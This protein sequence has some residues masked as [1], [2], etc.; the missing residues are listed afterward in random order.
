MMNAIQRRVLR[1]FVES[2]GDLTDAAQVDVLVRRVETMVCLLPPALRA[3]VEIT[4]DVER[5]VDY[6]FIATE[7][8][9]REGRPVTPVTARQRV[10]R[11][12]RALE[13]WI[14]ARPWKVPEIRAATD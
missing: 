9:L 3:A 8:S 2:G 4:W 7:L 6:D 13:R 10:S 11:G 5:D 12:V 14:R 1:A